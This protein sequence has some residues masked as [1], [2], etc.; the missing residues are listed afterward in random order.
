MGSAFSSA[1]N[2]SAFRGERSPVLLAG[3]HRARLVEPEH[4][5]N[6]ALTRFEP[7]KNGLGVTVGRALETPSHGNGVIED[8]RHARP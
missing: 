2:S 8:K 4:G 1:M 6:G 5:H 3:Q 7:V